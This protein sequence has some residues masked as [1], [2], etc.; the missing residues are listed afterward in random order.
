MFDEPG[1]GDDVADP[2]R[3]GGDPLHHPNGGGQD[4]FDLLGGLSLAVV[5]GALNGRG[6]P[7]IHGESA[8]AGSDHEVA[9][10]GA[11]RLAADVQHLAGP[12][13]VLGLV[14]P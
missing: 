8:S 13:R 11:R 9:V 2:R 3:L 7:G 6:H 12:L 4:A 14:S 10:L 1:L 5:E